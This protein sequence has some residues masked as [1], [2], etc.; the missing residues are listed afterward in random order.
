MVFLNG[1]LPTSFYSCWSFNKIVSKKFPKTR[2]EPRNSGIGSNH[3]INCVITATVQRMQSSECG[4]LISRTV[5]CIKATFFR[6]AQLQMPELTSCSRQKME[7]NR[8]KLQIRKYKK[9]FVECHRTL[10]ITMKF[11]SESRLKNN[12]GS[13]NKILFN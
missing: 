3:S 12:F 7:S 11:N 5:Q 4:W 9:W 2:F 6:V 10:M 8:A 13:K 1:I